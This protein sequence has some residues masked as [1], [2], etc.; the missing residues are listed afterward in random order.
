MSGP[1]QNTVW[2]QEEQITMKLI[3]YYIVLY[4]QFK[5]DRLIR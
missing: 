1:Q 4:F 3:V 2:I 5:T